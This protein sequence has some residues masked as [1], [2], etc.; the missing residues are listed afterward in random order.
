MRITF[1]GTGAA[2]GI[3]AIGCEC[4]HCQRARR[5]DGKLQRERNALCVELPGY[6]LLIEVPPDI[7]TLINE[8][9]ITHLDGLL[10]TRARYDHIG[11]LVEFEYWPE[12]LDL[13]AEDHLYEHIRQEHWSP[14]L[15]RIV[16][17]I[18]YY[19][20]TPLYFD[21]FL[22]LPFAVRRREPIFGVLLQEPERGVRVV[23]TSDTP[24]R[25]TN[26][27]R[28]L[29]RGADLLIVNTPTFEP[30]KEDHITVTEAIRLHRDVEAK[31]MILTYISH[32]NKPHDDLEAFL[33]P[34]SGVEVAYDGMTVE[35]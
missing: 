31:R 7:R 22:L 2:E 6:T 1:L 11:G 15:E 20:G 13:L 10:A 17:H 8:Y 21:K 12:R 4:P 14:Y 19:P 18:P 32:N 28:H 34:Y 26:Y 35:I 30:P 25:L 9:G 3:P 33:R 16:F 27:A 24:N 5:E 23:Y 29:M